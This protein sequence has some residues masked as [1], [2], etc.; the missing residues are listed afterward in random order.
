[1]ATFFGAS[2]SGMCKHTIALGFLRLK[3]KYTCLGLPRYMVGNACLR[4]AANHSM[5]VGGQSGNSTYYISTYYMQYI[6]HF[7]QITCPIRPKSPR[8]ASPRCR[9][10]HLV[11]AGSS[12][13]RP[14]PSCPIWYRHVAIGGRPSIRC[15]RPT[16]FPPFSPK[17]CHEFCAHLCVRQGLRLETR[18]TTPTT[19]RCSVLHTLYYVYTSTSHYIPVPPSTSSRC[20]YQPQ[21]EST[22][23][24]I[25][26]IGQ[27]APAPQ[28]TVTSG[29]P[30]S[31]LFSPALPGQASRRSAFLDAEQYDPAVRTLEKSD[32]EQKGGGVP[33]LPGKNKI[34]AEQ[35]GGPRIGVG[36]TSQ[37]ATGHV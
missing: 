19:R 7:A 8:G 32:S 18:P 9:S 24:F 3:Q 14:V 10:L 33:P 5:A 26:R 29:F 17:F 12:P 1:M 23:V 2:R 20:K 34:K 27:V 4:A 21:A 6:V 28:T 35:S 13:S 37:G 36:R 15:R 30:P 22:A 25:R 16:C 31:R 11:P